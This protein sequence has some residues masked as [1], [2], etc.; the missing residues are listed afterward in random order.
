MGTN[1][2]KNLLLDG[3]HFSRFDAH[4]GVA[5]ATIRNCT[6][7]HMGVKLIGHGEF[8]MENT[9]V[10]SGNLI[11]FRRDYG[12]TWRGDITIRNCTF[13]PNRGRGNSISLF[14]GSND[15]QHDFGYTCYM[16]A[17]ITIENLRIEDK[18]RGQDY[19]GPVIF[20][21]FN[22]AFKTDAYEQPFPY[23][24]T[25][26]VIVKNVTTASGKPLRVS[27]NPH[28]FRNVVIKEE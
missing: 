12:S 28:M 6:L 20:A 1:E 5:N 10:Y 26:E 25:R 13:V 15:G 4:R 14:G 7:G 27:S 3:C 8:L 21:N 24:I 19:A 23:V 17:R 16:P 22:P 2:N 18:N 11:G 9:T